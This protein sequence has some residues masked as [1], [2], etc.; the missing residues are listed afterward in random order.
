M[1]SKEV[2]SQTDARSDIFSLGMV[3]AELPGVPHRNRLKASC[4]LCAD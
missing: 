1:N 3:M 4:S 2:F